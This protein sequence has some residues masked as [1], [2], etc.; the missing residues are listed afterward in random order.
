MSEKLDGLEKECAE[1]ANRIAREVNVYEIDP[2]EYARGFAAFIH[3][4]IASLQRIIHQQNEERSA[5]N[6]ENEKNYN[7]LL[8]RIAA[9][10]AA[11]RLDEAKWWMSAMCSPA[12]KGTE[13]GERIA[14]LERGR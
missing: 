14:E 10:E 3:T 12:P 1:L 2:Q 11:A 4:R 8:G 13:L 6:A 5:I 9:A 7:E